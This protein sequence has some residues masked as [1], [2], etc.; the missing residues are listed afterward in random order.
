M[1]PT[2]AH[3]AFV[4]CQLI[5]VIPKQFELYGGCAWVLYLA[6]HRFIQKVW[7]SRTLALL[8]QGYRGRKRKVV[9]WSAP[10]N[11]RDRP[12]HLPPSHRTFPWGLTRGQLSFV[13]SLDLCLAN[14]FFFLWSGLDSRIISSSS[15]VGSQFSLPFWREEERKTRFV[16]ISCVT[17]WA[18]SAHSPDIFTCTN[19]H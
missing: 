6:W 17:G 19:D 4:L 2:Y 11:K 13:L 1:P 7:S 16:V 10:L 14:L 3:M 9:G 5:E 18:S 15:N 12:S 8:L